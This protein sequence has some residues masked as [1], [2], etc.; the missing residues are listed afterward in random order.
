MLATLNYVV[1]NMQ[2]GMDS[3]N[4]KESELHFKVQLATKK[5]VA[6]WTVDEEKRL[7]E[8][9]PIN[10]NLYISQILN[11]SKASIDKKGSSLGLKKSINYRQKVS[12]QNNRS[13]RHAWTEKDITFLKENYIKKSYI[14]IAETLKRTPTAVSQKARKINLVKH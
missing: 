2:T 14:E 1:S 6:S 4:C 7:I 11:K 12:R 9:Y 13:K 10:S 3:Y 8:L 5:S